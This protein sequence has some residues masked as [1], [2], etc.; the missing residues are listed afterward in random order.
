MIKFKNVF[1]HWAILKSGNSYNIQRLKIRLTNFSYKDAMLNILTLVGTELEDDDDG[2]DAEYQD[3]FDDWVDSFDLNNS[4]LQRRVRRRGSR[5]S[6]RGRALRSIGSL[7]GRIGK[8][9]QLE[10]V[11]EVEEAYVAGYCEASCQAN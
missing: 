9:L 7:K 5:G 4:R 1:G 2:Q 6:V 10:E 11:T 8:K 3:C